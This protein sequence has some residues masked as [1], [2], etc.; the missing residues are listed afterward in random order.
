MTCYSIENGVVCMAN[1]GFKCPHCEKAYSDLNDKYLNRCNKNKS[2]YTKIK[3]ECG[4]SF[5]MTYDYMGNAQ[6]FQI[7]KENRL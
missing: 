2:G 5:Y 1:I 7:N 6:S 3:C 4:T